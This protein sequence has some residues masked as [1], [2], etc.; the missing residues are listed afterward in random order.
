[1]KRRAR[2]SSTKQR[3]DASRRVLLDRLKEIAGQI[4]L[5]V[6]E[7]RLVREVGYRVRSG[8]VR[9]ETREIVFLDTNADI[10]ERIDVLADVLAARDLDSMYIEPEIRELL[11]GRTT[12]EPRSAEG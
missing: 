4:G 11:T 5:E 8:P 1:M 10:A 3:P 2:K 9:V 12:T 7:E 6:R